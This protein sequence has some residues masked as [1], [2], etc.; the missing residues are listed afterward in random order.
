MSLADFPRAKDYVFTWPSELEKPGE[1]LPQN[2]GFE[3]G[4]MLLRIRTQ[5]IPY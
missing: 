4:G 2:F 3:I 1:H 5:S